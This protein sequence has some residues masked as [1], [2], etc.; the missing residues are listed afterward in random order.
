MYMNE[1]EFEF[2]I[3]LLW[4]PK[5]MDAIDVPPLVAVNFLH[6]PLYLGN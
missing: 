1:I 6:L 4:W 5:A 3:A 2:A